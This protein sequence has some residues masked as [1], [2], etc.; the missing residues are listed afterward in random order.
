M[1]Y[2]KAIF[3]QER[4]ISLT[5]VALVFLAWSLVTAKELV[6][7]VFL[8]SPYAVNMAANNAIT[9]RYIL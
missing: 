5:T 7:P 6:S 2:L 3:T 9:K 4:V 8:P 1:L